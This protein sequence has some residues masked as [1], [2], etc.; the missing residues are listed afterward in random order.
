MVKARAYSPSRLQVYQTC[1]RKYYYQYVIKVPTRRFAEQSVGISLHGA[2]EEV[3]AAGGV[4]AT[5]MDGALAML[6]A[7]WEGEGFADAAEEAE[8]RRRAEGLLK[9]YLARFGDGPGRPVMIEQKLEGTFLGVPFLGI[10]DRVDEL[11]DGTL[12]L[13]DYKSGRTREVTAPVRQQLAIYRHLIK[14]KLGAYP[15]A[16]SVHHLASSERVAVALPPDE[17]DA[18]LAGA[19]DSARAIEHDQDYTP[20]VGSWCRRCDFASRCLAFKRHQRELVEAT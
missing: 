18:T 13:I 17:W 4:A 7:R 6:L 9:E 16:V 1:A 5:G 11:P 3:Q 8:A 14:E 10:V 12:E 15:A 2:L 19:A 20:Q